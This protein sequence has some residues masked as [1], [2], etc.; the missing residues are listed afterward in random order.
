MIGK[1]WSPEMRV[2]MGLR[3]T[4]DETRKK[5][6]EASKGRKHTPEAIAKMRIAQQKPPL[7]EETKRKLSI[8]LNSRTD[9]QKAET[10][11]KQLEKKKRIELSVF[12]KETGAWVGDYI[13]IYDCCRTLGLATTTVNRILRKEGVSLDQT[14]YTFKITQ[15]TW[16]S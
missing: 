6:S 14:G 8:S 12:D 15:R 4:K 16:L 1:T 13:S 3:V 5:L 7:S 10:K 9:E 2:K 11:R